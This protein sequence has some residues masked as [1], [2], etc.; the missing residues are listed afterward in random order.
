MVEPDSRHLLYEVW[1]EPMNN[2][3]GFWAVWSALAVI[4]FWCV[5]LSR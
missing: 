3:Q 5:W 1:G 2:L 4:A